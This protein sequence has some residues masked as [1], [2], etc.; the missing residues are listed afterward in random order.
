MNLRAVL[1]LMF[2]CY[3]AVL[4]TLTHLPRPPSVFEGVSDKKLHVAAYFTL[5]GLVFAAMAL[6]FPKVRGLA[7]LTIF[8]GGLF[9]IID[10]STQPLFGRTADVH[11]WAADMLGLLTAVWL[12]ALI[13][14]AIARAASAKTPREAAN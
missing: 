4:L 2:A 13:R 11:D 6:T 5:G 10:E 1:W 7:S 9:G 8:S 14:R 12:L 3:V